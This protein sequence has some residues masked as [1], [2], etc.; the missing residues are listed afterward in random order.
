MKLLPLL[1]LAWSP[2]ATAQ[3]D[4]RGL[5]QVANVH[6][7][8]GSRRVIDPAHALIYQLDT[9]GMRALLAQ[10]AE[11]TLQDMPAAQQHIQLPLPDGGFRMFRFLQTP[12]MQAGLQ[13]RYPFIRTYSGV[14]EDDA[15][16]TLKF[17]LTPAG[18]HAMVIG[19]PEGDAFIDPVAMGNSILHQ[20]YWS[21]DLAQ[22]SSRAP[23]IC[24]YDQVNDLP[25]AMALSAQWIASAGNA[26]TGDCQ[27]RTYRLALACTGEYANYF[28]A[29]GTDKAPAIAAMATSLNRVNGIY[30]RDA[31]LTMVL[32]DN[33]DQLVFTD[34]ATDGY[35]NNDGGTMLGENQT[36]CDSVIG[37]PNYDIGHV[38]STG[39][40]GVAY[41][42]SPCTDYKAGGVTGLTDPVGD[43][44]DIDYVA[45]EM[46]HQYG[47]NHTQNNDCNRADEAAVEVGS[48]ITI[49]GYAGV[50]PPNVADH[51]IAIFGGYS[52]QEIHGNITTGNSSTCPLTVALVNSPPTADAGTDRVIPK[53]TP[54]VLTATGTDP[55]ANDT[56]TYSW[57]QMDHQVS[58]QPP[59]A[60]SNNGPNFR[61]WLP[62]DSASRWFP[63]LST[64]VTNTPA[65]P[66]W[67]VLASVGRSYHFRVTVRDNAVGG[68]CITQDDM[69]V[70]VNS[71]S[72]PFVVT[73]PNTALTW[74]ASTTQIVT[75]DPAGTAGSP[76]NCANVDILLSTD[77]GYTYPDTLLTGT[78]NDGSAAVTLPNV[79][80]SAARVMV[81]ANGNIFFDIG[82][83]NYNIV[84]P[85][86]LRLNAKAWLE[87]PYDGSGLMQDDLRSANVLPTTEPY[88]DL[89][90][91]QIGN[92]GGESCSAAV[93]AVTGNTAVVDWIR[94][95]LRDA[96]S[97][98][99]LACS[100]QALI[101]RNGQIVDVDGISP[102]AF[103]AP[104]GSYY[105][106]IRHRNHLGCMTASAIAL[107][108]TA[109]SVD[110]TLP[111]T[112]VYGTDARKVVGSEEEL[113]MGNV[114]SDNAIRYTG[115]A[116]DRDPIIARIGGLDPAST[117]AGYYVEDC[118]MDG[119]VSYTGS[120]NDRDPI[121]VN[122]GGIMPTAI[123]MEQLP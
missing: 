81:R 24:S 82:D 112:A 66:N 93:L 15:A 65:S 89:G 16:V 79:A 107:G 71:G 29:F 42:Q 19:L 105:V 90:Y 40:G 106:V 28:G 92:G 49:M 51:S 27:F 45:H 12:L 62:T 37:S 11:G 35:S 22:L 69:T 17:D 52:L 80:T 8:H 38:F 63:Q 25:H 67:E 33:D 108:A 95:E 109:T 21:S 4:S 14:A 57:E 74:S 97:S 120:G 36:K 5:W 114:N 9:S 2:F 88:S 3:A 7:E 85:D 1:F 43:S 20:A 68:G 55:D 94:L 77:G 58:T 32:V 13:S 6:M 70:T 54:F 64:L 102:V 23:F 118:T 121:L 98:G 116:N 91:E 75:W 84:L 101:L 113:W 76:V 122:V 99:L 123:R 100:R 26:R 30:E 111:S 86:T 34:P 73:Q 47:G 41:L 104:S 60:T 44:F 59:V 50:C 103:N 46:G 61:P 96:N 39:G 110:F 115:A 117:V 119:V 83:S 87:G 72:G 78:A 31:T 56:L 53:S 48:G 18:F 10:A